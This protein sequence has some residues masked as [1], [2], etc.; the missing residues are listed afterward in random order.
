MNAESATH[1]LQAIAKLLQGR[2]NEGLSY[3]TLQAAGF[4]YICQLQEV[5]Q[6][7]VCS[8]T[9]GKWIAVAVSV[10]LPEQYF[11]LMLSKRGCHNCILNT[12]GQ[13]LV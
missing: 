9:A 13:S 2:A 8:C 1:N 4:G 10:K 3:Q 6:S 12:S 11:C 5:S 7:M